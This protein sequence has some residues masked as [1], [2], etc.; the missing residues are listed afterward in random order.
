MGNRRF[1]HL[2]RARRSDVPGDLL[3]R[4]G[5][6]FI[7]WY[8]HRGADYDVYAQRI[9]H[10]GNALWAP[11]GIGVCTAPGTQGYTSDYYYVGYRVLIP[12]GSGGMITAWHD[13]RSGSYNIY[14]Q[15][16]DAAG[17]GLWTPNGVLIAASSK[18]LQ[19][20]VLTKDGASGA[21]V[22]FADGWHASGSTNVHAQ[23]VDAS[24]SPMWG[25]SGVVV[26]SAN[27]Y[28]T[29]SDIVSDDAG[30]A[31]MAW[32]DGR[33]GGYYN[34]QIWAQRV[35]ASGNTVW[36]ANGIPID[37]TPGDSGWPVL[38]KD[39]MGG[40][41]IAWSS[42]HAITRG[43]VRAQRVDAAGNVQW[44]VN[45]VDVSA[46]VD[47][48]GNVGI[49]P[50][51]AG[52]AIVS[53]AQTPVGQSIQDVYAQ[54]IDAAGNIHWGPSGVAVCTA[55]DM[56]Y[57][58]R[59]ASLASDGHGGV[60]LAW[61]DRR[62]GSDF[63]IYA[64][65]LNHNGELRPTYALDIKPGSC[66]NPM[67]I[68]LWEMERPPMNAKAKKGGVLPVA[69][70]GSEIGD[71]H[72]I[73]FSTVLLEGVPPLR[74][75]YGDV[76]TPA[77]GS[78]CD[79]TRMG[80]DGFMDLTLKFFKMDIVE[81]MGMVSAG[82]IRTLT[83]TGELLDGT[84][85]ELTDCVVTVGRDEQPVIASNSELLLNPAEPNPFNPVTRIGYVLPEESFVSLSIFDVRGKLIE[86]LVATTE[87]AGEH[88]V[89]WNAAGLPSGIYFCHLHVGDSN[90]TR[91]LILL[92]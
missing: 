7:T 62:S 2:F 12:D 56:Q 18:H 51:G 31:I 10:A 30:G 91:K 81:A 49:V 38:L 54:R 87:S 46:D 20:P 89:K 83:L 3:G 29:F 25:A 75:S 86:Q 5:G 22:V 85:F 61:Q 80:A 53:W 73:D 19:I 59:S 21:I 71:V 14:A 77:N 1:D 60:I 28:Q 63:D 15:R 52:G 36:P 41:I 74:H 64:L 11:N 84:P 47:S 92:K 78:G 55:P 44:T 26:C 37:T 66:P 33:P 4:R 82:D 17:N 13:N 8:D 68:K 88:V 45:G 57:G 24:G 32:I 69:I 35:D 72:D 48:E 79:C 76:A 43:D 50:D 70:L 23:R 65:R 90:Q 34:D 58:S 42:G 67:N 27:N 6:A 9:D 39:G 16:L 40:A